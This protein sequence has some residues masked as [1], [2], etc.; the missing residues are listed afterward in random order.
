MRDGAYKLLLASSKRDQVLNVSKSLLTSNA[1]VRAYLAQLQKK[2]EEEE[3]LM[4][5]TRRLVRRGSRSL[6]Q[7]RPALNPC[8]LPKDMYLNQ[9]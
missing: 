2:K 8:F 1:R 9:L 6:G 4:G 7:V 3:D 5:A